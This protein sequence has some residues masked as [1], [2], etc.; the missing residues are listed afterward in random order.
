MMKEITEIEALA[1]AAAYCSV[2]EHC[3][4]EVQ[5]KLAQ[6]GM[7]AEASAR[8]LKRLTDERYIDE[9]RYCHFFVEDK[10]RHNKWGRVKMRQALWQKRIDES[11]VEEALGEIDER[12]YTSILETLIR[13]KRKSVKANSDYEL[14]GKLI[15]FALGRGFEMKQI[16]RV[17]SVDDY[18]GED[19]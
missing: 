1:K 11:I 8:I 16:R 14:N 2:A 19:E 10:V 15:R 7:D 4:S 5:A 3:L 12:E 13:A 18:E 6:W 9:H 17:L